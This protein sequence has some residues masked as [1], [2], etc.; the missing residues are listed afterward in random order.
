MNY[1]NKQNIEEYI[2]DYY[3]GNLNENQ[4][5]EVM[6]FIHQH[7][8]YE[9]LFAQWAM[10]YTLKDEEP[11]KYGMENSWMKKEAN[12]FQWKKWSTVLAVAIITFWGIYNWQ[13]S[14]STSI[15]KQNQTIT[16]K[17]K[18]SSTIT[19]QNEY[20]KPVINKQFKSENNITDLQN[21]ITK[22]DVN[23]DV[24]QNN[25]SIVRNI[26]LTKIIIEDEPKIYT[27]PKLSKVD[28]SDA[29][30]LT[31]EANAAKKAK[32]KKIKLH[33]NFKQHDEFKPVNE[34]F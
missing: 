6:S 7:Q 21:S 25:D 13:T 32:K 31:K 14:L 17:P 26:D 12:S 27:E 24:I 10:T 9:S 5:A 34:N 19:S 1:I 16:S 15:D 29:N 23:Q 33:L 2:F 20:V 28:S 3:E 8:E 22:I 30:T 11:E 18:L 4:K